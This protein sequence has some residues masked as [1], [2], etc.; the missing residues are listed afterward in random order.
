MADKKEAKKEVVET[1]EVEKF[2]VPS[3]N[4]YL[5]KEEILKLEK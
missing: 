4:K 3:V 1:K 2:Y 5:T